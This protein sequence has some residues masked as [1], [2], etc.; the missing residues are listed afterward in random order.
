MAAVAEDMD[1]RYETNYNEAGSSTTSGATE[2]NGK[3]TLWV[4]NRVPVRHSSEPMYRLQS[5]RALFAGKYAADVNTTDTFETT[6]PT[7]GH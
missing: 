3:L 4:A 7:T 6:P 1:K 2:V 5:H